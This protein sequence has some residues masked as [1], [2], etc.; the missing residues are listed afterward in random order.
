MSVDLTS[1]ADLTSAFRPRFTP[2]FNS[3]NLSARLVLVGI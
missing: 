2:G 1:H 3:R